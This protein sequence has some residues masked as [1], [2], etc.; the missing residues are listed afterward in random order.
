M[1]PFQ[2][3]YVFNQFVIPPDIANIPTDFI[4]SENTGEIKPA[5]KH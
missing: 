4:S 3:A 1:A 5:P 2:K